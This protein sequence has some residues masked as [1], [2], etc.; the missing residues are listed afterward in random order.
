M[1]IPV[2]VVR[3]VRLRNVTRFSHP[4]NWPHQLFFDTCAKPAVKSRLMIDW[5]FAPSICGSPIGG[6]FSFVAASAGNWRLGENV[7]RV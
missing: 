7:N 3:L 5:G 1:S 6:P 4:D 2:P